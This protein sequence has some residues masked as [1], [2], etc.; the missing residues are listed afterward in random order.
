MKTTIVHIQEV[1]QTLTHINIFLKKAHI[2]IKMLN[3][4]IKE[5]N[6]KSSQRKK[7]QVHTEE[8]NIPAM[9]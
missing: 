2:I 3:A 7:R 6:L 9:R 8:Q 1:Q 5:K 4:N